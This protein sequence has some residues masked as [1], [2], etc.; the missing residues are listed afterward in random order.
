MTWLF[1]GYSTTRLDITSRRPGPDALVYAIGIEQRY[2][3]TRPSYSDR[4][5]QIRLMLATR[6]FGYFIPVN[7]RAAPGV[8][9]AYYS[10]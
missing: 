5:Q 6:R 8:F 4:L 1:V 3:Y 9:I 10:S 7:I 2:T